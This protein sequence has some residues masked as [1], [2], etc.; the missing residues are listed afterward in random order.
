MTIDERVSHLLVTLQAKAPEAEARL[1]KGWRG[2]RFRRGKTL[3]FGRPSLTL[4]VYDP[5]GSRQTVFVWDFF[6]NTNQYGGEYPAHSRT[7]C[8][9]SIPDAVMGAA[10]VFVEEIES[11]ARKAGGYT[12]AK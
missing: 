4:S 1:P 7:A 2:F 6:L 3:T 5:N 11:L 12:Y 9:M 10:W 8:P